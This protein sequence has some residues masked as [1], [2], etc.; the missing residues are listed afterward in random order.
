M[1]RCKIILNEA[2]IFVEEDCPLYRAVC[3]GNCKCRGGYYDSMTF[4]FEKCPYCT[5]L[6]GTS[7]NITNT[8]TFE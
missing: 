2:P 1:S 7:L 4:E 8:V 3:Q 5:T 6:A